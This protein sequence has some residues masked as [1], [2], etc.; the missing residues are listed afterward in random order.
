MKIIRG[1]KI[2]GLQQKI[3]NLMLIFILALIGVFAAVSVYQQR[4]L[5]NTVQQANAEQQASITAISEQTMEAVLETTVSR[6]TALQAYIANDLFADVRTSVLTL[7]TFASGLFD[8]AAL[9]SPHPF[10]EPD[11]AND[12]KASVQVQHEEGVDPAQSEALGLVANMSELMLAMFENSEKLSSCFVATPD[13]CIL[14]VDDR[15]GSYFTDTGEVVTFDEDVLEEGS[16]QCPACGETLEF[17][18][19]SD[20]EEKPE[21]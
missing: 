19:G 18:L 9:F 16:I 10:Y 8:H 1:I 17:D 7:Q 11:A 21:E 2:G 15:A 14:Y 5:S 3:L 6:S 13:G 20:E 4:N 12:G